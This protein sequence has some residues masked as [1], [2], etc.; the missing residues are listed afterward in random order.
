MADALCGPSNALQN[1]QKHTTADRTLQQERLISRGGPTQGFRSVSGQNA[2]VLDSEFEAFQAGQLPLSPSDPSN[3]RPQA[4]SPTHQHVQQQSSATW[5]SDFQRLSLSSPATPIQQQPL[6][7]YH[8]QQIQN[9]GGWHQEFALQQSQ[10]ANIPAVQSQSR[11]Y[12]PLYQNHMVSGVAEPSNFTGGFAEAHHEQVSSEDKQAELFN[13]EAFARA[14][15]E[16]SRM[17][18]QMRQE[19]EQTQAGMETEYVIT[20]EQTEEDL[21][22]DIPE[23]QIRIGADLIH[24]PRDQ[25]QQIHQE[26]EDPDALARTAAQL[27][28]SVKDNQSEKFKNSTFLELMRQLRDREVKV[29]GDQIVYTDTADSEAIKVAST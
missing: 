11:Q 9:V 25:E 14:F 6:V 20:K 16:A 5:A 7:P 13:E 15:E 29:E 19:L 10:M 4:F 8:P 17:E 18:E 26:Q 22:T 1:F 12:V 27:L 28:D 21:E 3:F 2:G 23:E 24:D